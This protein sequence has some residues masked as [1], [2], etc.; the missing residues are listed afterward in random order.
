MGKMRTPKIADKLRKHSPLRPI[1]LGTSIWI[2]VMQILRYL[3]L[4]ERI[5][6]IARVLELLL[7]SIE[8][9]QVKELN[10]TLTPEVCYT[11]SSRQP[12]RDDIRR[13]IL[14]NYCDIHRNWKSGK[15]HSS[16]L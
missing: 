4:K 15:V 13:V 16:E 8:D 10:K 7:T 11:F 5:V 14:T 1:L 2:S 6:Q 9:N 12:N 3:V